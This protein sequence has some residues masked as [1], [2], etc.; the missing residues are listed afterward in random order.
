MF[1]RMC[2]KVMISI[3]NDAVFDTVNGS[4][5]HVV[6]GHGWG[7]RNFKICNY[8]AV[9]WAHDTVNFPIGHHVSVL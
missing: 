8:C 6:F 1:F 3:I 9:L 5:K 4:E 7:Y 2:D